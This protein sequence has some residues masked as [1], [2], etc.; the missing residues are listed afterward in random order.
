M[1]MG[2]SSRSDKPIDSEWAGCLVGLRM[3][4]PDH[5][6]QGQN[7]NNL[8]DGRLTFFEETVSRWGLV[9]DDVD[10]DEPYLM[11]YDA[12]LKYCDIDASTYANYTL[13]AKPIKQPEQ[14]AVIHGKTYV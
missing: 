4:V 2:T 3:K 12:V 5:W 13:P 14:E 11:R 7:G 9:L 8:H 10:D 6:W 1:V